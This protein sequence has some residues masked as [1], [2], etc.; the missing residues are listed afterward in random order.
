MDD[1]FENKIKEY[2]SVI[3]NAK[4]FLPKVE[5][6][7]YLEK[8][9]NECLRNYTPTYNTKYDIFIDLLK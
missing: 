6:L 5:K 9:K 4:T 1:Y 8:L 3:V 7:K 2:F